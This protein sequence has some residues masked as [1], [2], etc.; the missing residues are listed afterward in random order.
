[1]VCG[2]IVVFF[3]ILID[4]LYLP[5]FEITLGYSILCVLFILVEVK[6]ILYSRVCWLVIAAVIR[7][8]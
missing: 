8:L 3:A 2:L 4:L 7:T 6:D 1:M 5:L